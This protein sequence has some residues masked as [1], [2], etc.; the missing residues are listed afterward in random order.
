MADEFLSCFSVDKKFIEKVTSLV[1]WHMQIL[2]INKNSKHQN[3]R[4]MVKEVDTHEIVLVCMCDR[5][6][7]GGTTYKEAD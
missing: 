5:L 3:V 4:Q 1:R 2:F 6:G 7:R